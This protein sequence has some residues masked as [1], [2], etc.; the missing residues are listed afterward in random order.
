VEFCPDMDEGEGTAAY[1]AELARTG[2]SF[3]WWD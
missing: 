1:A 2:D 3:F